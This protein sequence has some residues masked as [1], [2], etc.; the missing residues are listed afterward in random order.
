M[1]PSV[2]QAEPSCNNKFR[3]TFVTDVILNLF[4]EL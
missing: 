3:M 1:N 4:L 2:S